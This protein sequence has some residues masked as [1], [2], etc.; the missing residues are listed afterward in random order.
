[1]RLVYIIL[2]FISVLCLPALSLADGAMAGNP[3]PYFKVLSGEKET[4]TL[5]NLKG[6]VAVLFYE[7]KNTIE[8]NRNLKVRLNIFYTALSPSAKKDIVRAGIINCRDVLFR[9]FWEKELRDNSLKERII[10]YGDWDGQMSVAYRAAENE[11]NI[12]IIDRK[13]LIRYQACGPVKDEDIAEIEALIRN[14]A[15][16]K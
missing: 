1:M 6:K 11:S 14:L 4:L 15:R 13:G 5:D 7:T 8:R 10:I 3:A 9:G 12:I 16:G 2:L